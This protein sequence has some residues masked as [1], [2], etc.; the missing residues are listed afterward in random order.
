MS[1]E[2]PGD[3]VDLVDVQLP[4][5]RE[6]VNAG[7][8]SH[9]RHVHEGPCAVLD[10]VALRGFK[11]GGQ[12]ARCRDHPFTPDVLV[13]VVED[14]GLLRSTDGSFDR[15]ERDLRIRANG[16]LQVEEVLAERFDDATAFEMAIG[17]E[18]RLG[19]R[20][21]PHHVDADGRTTEP[22]LQDVGAVERERRRVRGQ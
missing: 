8:T 2:R 5:V 19:G 4:I 3:G 6:K 17:A 21:V 1:S 13:A 15:R 7:H 16:D 10:L 22:R 14:L 20:Q 12:F 18:T 9:R 11:H